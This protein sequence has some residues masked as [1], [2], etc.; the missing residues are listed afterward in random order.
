MPLGLLG[1]RRFGLVLGLVALLRATGLAAA[2]PMPL[3]PDLQVPLILKILTYDR[4]FEAKAGRDL[5]I[6]IVYAPADPSSVKAANDISDTLF[7]FA[8]KTVKRLGIRYFLIEFTTP[9]KLEQS[10]AQRGISVLYLAPGNAKNLAAVTK[11]SQARGITTATGVPDYVRKGVSVGIGIADDRP[12]IL[13]N[14]PST[15][16][17]GSEFDLSLLRIATVLK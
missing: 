14:L 17:E 3:T 4:H 13:I 10:I 7:R 16:A 11:V 8:G 9:E 2:E 5:A 12:Q 1:F 15:K 6:G